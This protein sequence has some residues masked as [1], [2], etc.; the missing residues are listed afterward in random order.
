LTLHEIASWDK[1]VA[2]N[3][4]SFCGDQ[5]RK[6]GVFISHIGEEKAIAYSGDVNR[7]FRRI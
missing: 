4:R 5:K 7:V 1:I 6:E 3:E 2:K